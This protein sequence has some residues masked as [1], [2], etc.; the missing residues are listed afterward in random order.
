LIG[1]YRDFF[2]IGNQDDPVAADLFQIG[3]NGT[4]RPDAPDFFDEIITYTLEARLQG[5]AFND[6]LDWLAGAYY[7][8]EEITELFPFTNGADHATL[9]AAGAFGDPTFLGVASSVGNLLAGDGTFTPISNTGAFA[10]NLFSQEGDSFSFFTHNIFNITESLNVTVGLRYVNDSKSGSFE[11]LDVFNPA[12]DALLGAG[13]RLGGATGPADAA[14]ALAELEAVIGPAG[15]A[16]LTTPFGPGLPS[17][18]GFATA[19]SCLPFNAPAVPAGLGGGLLPELFNADFDDDEL[20]YTLQGGW[21]PSP[22]HLVYASFT[23]GYK[24]GG[25]NLDSSSAIGGADPSFNSE[26]ADAYEIGLKSTLFD[27]ALRANIALYY[28]DLD[29]F[30]AVEFTGTQFQTFNVADVSSKGVEVELVGQ[31]TDAISANASVYYTDAQFGDNC[32]VDAPNSAV[33]AFCG[34]RLGNAPEW[35][36]VFGA[37][38]DGEI[39]SSGWSTLANVN[40]RYESDRRTGLGFPVFLGTQDAN[41]KINARIGFTTP[42]G[43]YSL[44]FW[45]Q[46]LTDEITRSISFNTGLIGIP[47]MGTQAVSAFIEEPR[48]YGATVRAKF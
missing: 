4:A 24:A 8:N 2:A 40:F 20:I 39:G 17:G 14:A 15:A 9:V 31:L 6:R 35:V 5:T 37:T 7:A 12:C 34:F 32:D 43:K 22:N 47:A 16:G 10:D 25:I 13:G 33:S 19:L 3:P 1:S 48:T 26:E 45:G 44:E 36:S 21:K 11:Q 29:D 27:G 46:N 38:Y 41:L 30:Q 18:L 23:H 28:T 42:S